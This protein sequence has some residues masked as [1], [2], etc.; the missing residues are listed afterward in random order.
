MISAD[1]DMTA[2]SWAMDGTDES[3]WREGNDRS[4]RPLMRAFMA[5]FLSTAHV[6]VLSPAPSPAEGPSRMTP[7]DRLFM[8]LTPSGRRATVMVTVSDVDSDVR[9]IRG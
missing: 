9:S 4:H 5:R 6:P 3:G 1:S 7:T 8:D 2:N